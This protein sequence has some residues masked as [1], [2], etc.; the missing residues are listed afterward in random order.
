MTREEM[1]DILIKDRINEWVH[2]KCHEGLEEV[3]HVG[4]KGYENW[5]DKDV[6]DAF[7]DLLPENFDEETAQKVRIPQKAWSAN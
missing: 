1:I 5:S 3:L 6:M 4:W 7:L 2:A